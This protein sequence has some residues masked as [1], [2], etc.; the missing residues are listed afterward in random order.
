MGEKGEGVKKYKL[1]VTAYFRGC[2]VQHRKHSHNIVVTMSG[3]IWVF[4]L[5]G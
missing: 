2:T 4:D 5:S 3:V 1:V